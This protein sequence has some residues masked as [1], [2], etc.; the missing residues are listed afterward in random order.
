MAVKRKIKKILIK[1]D[2]KIALLSLNNPSGNC[3][4]TQLLEELDHC[5]EELLGDQ[6]VRVIL[7]TGSGKSF[8]QG[9]D[10]D[11]IV[12]INSAEQA[13]ETSVFGHKIFLKIENSPKPVIA[14]I[15]GFCLG[16]GLEL[17]M[18]CHIRIAS[19]RSVLGMPEVRLGMMP[20][21]GGTRR[22]PG[23]V[24]R[25]R[26]SRMI[27][28]GDSVRSEEALAIGLVDEVA[29]KEFLFDSAF[30]MAAKISE[31]SPATISQ[32]LR[33]IALGMD[34]DGFQG[35]D[36]ESRCVE[37][38]YAMHDI[39]R[40]LMAFIENR[41]SKSSWSEPVGGLEVEI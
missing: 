12:K 35:M 30:R 24:G 21:F 29:R 26:A 16:A 36:M 18:S 38:L 2:G 14:V 32:V 23:I 31:R 33:S 27:L 15:N 8:S 19:D 7:L 13:R 28:T 40:D 20:S 1:I 34:S 17:A 37:E 22:L 25:S 6:G 39:R 9:A 3:L 5:L 10:I 41:R 11:E 4:S